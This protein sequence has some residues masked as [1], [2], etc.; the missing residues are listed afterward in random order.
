M[1]INSHTEHDKAARYCFVPSYWLDISPW[2]GRTSLVLL[3]IGIFFA[4][5]GGAGARKISVACPD[6]A[7]GNILRDC[8][9]CT[10]FAAAPVNSSSSCPPTVAFLNTYAPPPYMNFT[11]AGDEYKLLVDSRP[12]N[13]TIIGPLR[14]PS[15]IIYNEVVVCLD[16]LQRDN[17]WHRHPDRWNYRPESGGYFVHVGDLACVDGR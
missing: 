13:P 17:L 11:P 8:K 5:S 6:D 7:P 10:V 4:G 2:S 12:S 16:A 15:I 1:C 9:R 3:L 14:V